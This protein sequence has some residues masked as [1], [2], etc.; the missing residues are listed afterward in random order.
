MQCV[1]ADRIARGSSSKARLKGLFF[2]SFFAAGRHATFGAVWIG[3]MNLLPKTRHCSVVWEAHLSL[4]VNFKSR[5]ESFG[6]AAG[7]ASNWSRR[8][9]DC[10]VQT[11]TVFD[12][13]IDITAPNMGQSVVSIGTVQ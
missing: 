1:Q 2:V 9:E 11:E 8:C 4:D 10:G 12:R 3:K 5:L 6:L 13:A 7:C